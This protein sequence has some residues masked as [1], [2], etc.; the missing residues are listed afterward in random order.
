MVLERGKSERRNCRTLKAPQVQL[1]SAL[2]ILNSGVRGLRRLSQWDEEAVRAFVASAL[3]C[4]VK[5]VT[6]LSQALKLLD[7]KSSVYELSKKKL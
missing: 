2:Y 1:F 7:L 3:W 4:T 6:A 5:V